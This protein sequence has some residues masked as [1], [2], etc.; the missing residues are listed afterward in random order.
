VAA[1]IESFVSKQGGTLVADMGV[2]LTNGVGARL[3]N[4]GPITRLLGFTRTGGDPTYEER[5]ARLKLRPGGKTVAVA[6]VGREKIQPLPGAECVGGDNG[7][8][9]CILTRRGKGRTIFLNCVAPD[10]AE[11]EEVFDGLPRFGE[12][13]S[14]DGSKRPRDYEL[15]QFERGANKYLAVI[16]D[17][18]NDDENYPVKIT[19]PAK[20]HIYD[21]RAGK[22]LGQKNV[23]AGEIAPGASRLFALLPCRSGKV[24]VGAAGGRFT[25]SITGDGEVGDRVVHVSVLRPD[26][27]E[28]PAYARNLVAVK[29]SVEFTI[30]FALNDPPGRWRVVCRDVATGLT[31]EAEVV[32]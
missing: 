12:V 31:G 14:A 30:P 23:V 16:H 7:V 11:L 2:G 24:E 29:G 6:C 1:E 25:C 10:L 20:A 3:R 13:T 15:V 9:D 19:L 8:P 32:R 26:G 22:Y 21:V 18:Q 5:Q 28:A 4:G 27:S 17:Y